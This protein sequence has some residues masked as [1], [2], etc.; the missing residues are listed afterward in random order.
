MESESIPNRKPDIQRVTAPKLSTTECYP[1]TESTCKSRLPECVSSTIES[2]VSSDINCCDYNHHQ[3]GAAPKNHDDDDGLEFYNQSPKL[4]RKIG[5]SPFNHHH[6]RVMADD[7]A[8]S[9]RD[10][11]T[12]GRCRS[13]DII[14]TQICTELDLVASHAPSIVVITPDEAISQILSNNNNSALLDGKSD[15]DGNHQPSNYNNKKTD[16]LDDDNDNMASDKL[17][18]MLD[19]ISQDLDYLLNR[20]DDEMRS[21]GTITTTVVT[22]TQTGCGGGSRKISKPPAPS[23]IQQI[24]EEEEDIKVPEA[25][26]DI[27]RTSC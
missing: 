18:G 15:D 2:F 13:P 21:S 6:Q 7:E 23:V 27:L 14:S 3:T 8:N 4:Y 20:G 5:S 19:S 1:M 22:A 11:R 9:H 24:Q 25:I 12:M 17:D 26:T 10:D 16:D